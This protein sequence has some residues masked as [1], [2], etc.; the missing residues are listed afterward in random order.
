VTARRRQSPITPREVIMTRR[1]N[2]VARVGVDPEVA[3]YRAAVVTGIRAMQTDA[4]IRD[5]ARITPDALT[6]SL[7]T[8]PR[9]C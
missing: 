6:S 7:S 8:D 3:Q 1:P 9:W 2:G 5:L 4:I